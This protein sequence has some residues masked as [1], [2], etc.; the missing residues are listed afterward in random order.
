MNCENV[1]KIN[2]K[3]LDNVFK[4]KLTSIS[5]ILK[6]GHKELLCKETLESFQMF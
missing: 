2:L 1:Y 6:E 5:S 3:F 4:D